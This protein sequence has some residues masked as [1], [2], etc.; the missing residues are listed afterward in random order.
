MVIQVNWGNFRAKFDGKE[1]ESFEWLC[2]LLFYREYN[3]P[4]GALRYLNQTAIETDPIDV[5]DEVVGWQAKFITSNLSKQKGTLIRAI[6]DAKK[7][8]P[9]LTRICFYLNVDFPSSSKSGVKDP[10]YKTEIEAHAKSGGVDITWKTA[11]FFETPFVC[12]D[13]ANIAKHFFTLEKTVIDFIEELS[14]HTQAILEPISSEIVFGNTTIKLDRSPLVRRLAQTLSRSS[15]VI[16]SGEAGVGK[17]ALVKDFYDEIKDSTPFFTF[18][19]A[20]FHITNVNQLF[21]EYGN[22]TLSDLVQEFIDTEDKY[23]VIDSAEKLSDIERP[24]VFTEFLSTL[25]SGGWKIIFTTRLSYLDDLRQAFIQIYNVTFEPLNVPSLSYEELIRLSVA[26]SFILPE[27]ERLRTLLENPFYLNEYLRNDPN[28]NAEL[29]YADFRNAM[30]NTQIAK[31]SYRKNNAHRRREE[32]FLEIARTRA[33][34]GRFFVTVPGFDDALGQLEADEIIKFDSNAGGYF[35]T[36]DIYEEWALEKLI[37]RAFH[38][39]QSYD[40]FYEDIGTSLP[41]RRAFRSW[42]SEKLALSGGDAPT[43][44]EATVNGEGIDRHWKDEVIVAA[45]LSYYASAFVENFGP[46]LLKEPEKAVEEGISSPAVRSFRGNHQYE[47]RLLYKV[48]FL[49]RIACKEVDQNVLNMLGNPHTELSLFF[50]K[51][52]G[53]GWNSV[54]AFLNKH[55]EELGLLYMHLILPVLDDWNCNNREGATT[56]EAAQ[57]GLFYYNELTKEDGHLPYSSRDET[58]EQLNRTIFN[59]SAEIAEELKAIFNEVITVKDTSHRGRY[60]ELVRTALSDLTKSAV[61]AQNLPTEVIAL[62][63]LFWFYTPPTGRGWYPDYRSSIGIEQYFD[64]ANNHADYYPTSAL[65]TPIFALLQASPKEAVDFI[66]AFTNKSI[67]YFAHSKFA[68]HEVEEVDVF[69]DT[70]RPIKQYICHRIWNIYRGT[71]VA[72]AVL[73]CMHMALERWLLLVLAK[74][75]TPEVLESWCLYLIKN[76]RSASITAVVASVVLAEADKL[77]NVA[78]VL[79]RTKAFFFFDTARIQLDMTAKGIYQISHDPYGI[80]KDERLSTCEDKQ[81]RL[82]LEHLALKYQLF[83]SEGEDEEIAKNRQDAIWEI[84]DDYCAQL[85][86][87]AKETEADKTWRLYLARMDTRKMNITTEAKGDK[88]LVSFNP[89]IDPELKKYSEDS[90]AKTS[91]AMKYTPLRLWARYR[92]ERNDSEYKK[93]SQYENDYQRVLADT[94]V[95]LV[96]LMHDE[97]HERTFTLFYHSVPAHACVVLMRDY[98]DQL[99]P[100]EKKFCK[101]TILEYASMPLESGYGYQ[102]GD[103]VDAA[104]NALPLL[105]KPFPEETTRVKETLLF[106]L[107]DSYPIGM[108]SYRFFDYAVSA[109]VEHMWDKHPADANGLFLGYLRLKPKFE[110]VGE[111]VRKEDWKKNVHELSQSAVVQRFIAE[112]ASEMAAVVA[113][114]IGNDEW[115]TLGDIDANTLVTAF[116]LLPLRTTDVDHKK[117]VKKICGILSRR[118]LERTENDEKF[119]YVLRQRFLEKLAHFVLL[120]SDKSEIETYMGPFLESIDDSRE[121]ASIFSEFVSAE[122]K[123]RQYDQFWVVWTLFYPRI[124]EFCKSSGTRFYASD[125]VHNYLLAW[126]FWRKDVKQWHSL[127]DRER[128]FFKKVAE[129]IGSHPAVLYSLSKLLNEIGS[130]FVDDGIGWISGILERNP[131]LSLKELEVNTVYYLE[132]LVRGYVLRNRYKVRTT[133]QVKQEI[134]TILNFLLEKGSATAYLLREDIL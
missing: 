43:L 105:L 17:T 86:D 15:L 100:E 46:E 48:L 13:N 99:A 36:H 55:K 106:V 60:Y 62:A 113:N 21:K 130:G 61:V 122:D 75:A 134:L 95:I 69:I 8:N 74:S 50:T 6:D 112:H 31:S 67:E 101:D 16:V 33:S 12:E 34:F 53:S 1:Q 54:I 47:G 38:A 131:D 30:W 57:I 10:S 28:G 39:S 85:P 29:T 14:R 2:S 52:K 92:Y 65:Q 108:S 68:E 78:Q 41:I 63:N 66:L 126:P 124:E 84:L 91:E 18:K 89:A 20:E 56:K 88:V 114:D 117:F 24:E 90:L 9:T 115:S 128:G 27:S 111:L 110:E 129:D 70:K 102:L 125:V 32:C 104:I 11:H 25:R 49:L 118:M 4:T 132:S 116:L 93:Y 76:S 3:R 5:G 107:F 109:I 73:E 23:V 121:A 120:T 80:F 79:F 72:P 35:I 96:G 119:D 123:L 82:S 40:R 7:E 64:L 26:Y 19:A 58:K 71:Q 45:L 133:P 87:R 77:F 94:K 127:K 37:E 98:F 51:P 83:R 22:F 103:G 59:G 44:I 97:S 42:L 81:R